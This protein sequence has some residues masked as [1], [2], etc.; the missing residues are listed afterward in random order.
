MV[1][2]S[3]GITGALIVAL[4]F[5]QMFYIKLYHSYEGRHHSHTVAPVPPEY[6]PENFAIRFPALWLSRMQHSTEYLNASLTRLDELRLSN[7]RW[8]RVPTSEWPMAWQKL[9]FPS[10]GK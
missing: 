4:C 9:R 5:A 1:W 2:Q 6:A 7:W 8:L 3:L 10:L